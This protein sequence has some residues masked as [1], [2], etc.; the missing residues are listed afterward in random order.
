MRVKNW[1]KETVVNVE[2][3]KKEEGLREDVDRI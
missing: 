3:F 1:P 2:T